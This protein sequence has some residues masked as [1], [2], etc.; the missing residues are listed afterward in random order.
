LRLYQSSVCLLEI[1]SLPSSTEVFA[2]DLLTYHA[3]RPF[4]S[5]AR[6]RC[7]IS[8]LIVVALQRRQQQRA[9]IP[10]FAS[11]TIAGHASSPGVADLVTIHKVPWAL[12]SSFRLPQWHFLCLKSPRINTAHTTLAAIG[13]TPGF[14]RWVSRGSEERPGDLNSVLYPQ[15]LGIAESI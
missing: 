9:V 15:T 11:F 1:F 3:L 12:K 7:L 4:I 14:G 10:V 8:R 13:C 6:S 2:T 5:V